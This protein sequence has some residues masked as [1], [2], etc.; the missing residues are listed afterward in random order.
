MAFF[1]LT[2]PDLQGF[3]SNSVVPEKMEDVIDIPSSEPSSIAEDMFRRAISIGLS[4][5]LTRSVIVRRLLFD[6][7]RAG[8]MYVFAEV[9]VVLVVSW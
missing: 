4:K 6:N 3:A 5:K 1:F 2:F 9:F 8:R 7:L